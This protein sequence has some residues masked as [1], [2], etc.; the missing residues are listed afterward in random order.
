MQK[1]EPDWRNKKV[2]F[3]L[4][5]NQSLKDVSSHLCG[6]W[7]FLANGLETLNVFPASEKQNQHV[8]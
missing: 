4:L 2:L 8:K 3:L 1:L 7:G 6:F 5:T